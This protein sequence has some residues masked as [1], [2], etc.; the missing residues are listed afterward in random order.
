MNQYYNA[1]MELTCAD[2]LLHIVKKWNTLSENL[3]T[4]AFDA[5]ILLPDIF[6]YTYP[7][8]GNTRMLELIANYLDSRKNLMSFY[9]DVKFFEF[10]LGYN[11]PG[12][13]FSELYRFADT[14]SAAA[15][16]R[17]EYRGVIRV[18]LD[19]WVEHC[20]DRH[21]LDF[22]AY[23]QEGTDRW[24]VILT[25]SSHERSEKTAQLEAIVSMYLR[26]ET[27]TIR[28]PETVELVEYARK[29]VGKYGLQLDESGAQVLQGAIDVLRE[30][31]HFYG[32]HTVSAL[33][34]DIVYAVFSRT[35]VRT[36]VLSAELLREFSAE[37]DYIKRSIIRKK[38]TATIGF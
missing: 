13:R 10:K 37:S 22:L 12:E 28:K 34:S 20:N 24:L 1:L 21:F 25:L 29:C 2:E 19:E 15:G 23:L 8:A 27:V 16:F 4:R 32:L 38:H 33:C 11:K 5:P 35:D 3:K 7:G 36:T 26:I 30:N 14:V 9:G 6:M 17:N 31:K 18:N